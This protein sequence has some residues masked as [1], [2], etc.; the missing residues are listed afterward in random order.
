MWPYCKLLPELPVPPE[1][2]YKHL[3][4]DRDNLPTHS[5]YH[6][7][8]VR[9]CRRDGKEFIASKGT[10]TP[11]SDEWED[12]VRKN[13][14]DGFTDTGINW[15]ESVS[16]TSG[17]HTDTTRDMAVMFNITTGGP[18]CGVTFWQ[19]KNHLLKRARDIHCLDFDR[20]EMKHRLIGPENVWFLID[21]RILHST[22][23]ITEPRV[24]F[25]IG[26]DYQQVP[27]HWINN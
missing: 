6:P 27:R 24:Q 5:P 21:A 25:Q 4:I 13:I 23:N 18:E 12:W 17:A 16:D 7:I 8:K 1:K 9:L 11:V 3:I 2:F 19:E 22:E 15:R 20:L 14:A 10:R 26:F